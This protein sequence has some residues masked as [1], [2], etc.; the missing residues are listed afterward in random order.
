MKIGRKIDHLNTKCSGIHV[1]ENNLYK[2][3]LQTW[4]FCLRKFTAFQL[5]N[6]SKCAL[7]NNQIDLT[8]FDVN[9]SFTASRLCKYFQWNL[10]GVFQCGFGRDWV[11]S[12]PVNFITLAKCVLSLVKA[13]LVANYQ[14]VL[15]VFNV[16][17]TLLIWRNIFFQGGFGGRSNIT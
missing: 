11:N 5:Y 17:I 3:T 7:A 9:H 2:P 12:Q 10:Q 16:Y 4:I 1:T 15:T 13:K 6:H 14:I 8:A